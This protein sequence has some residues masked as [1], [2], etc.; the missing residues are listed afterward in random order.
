MLLLRGPDKQWSCV[1][2]VPPL[3]ISSTQI[4]IHTCNCLNPLIHY[5]ALEGPNRFCR[6]GLL[7]QLQLGREERVIIICFFALN[8]KLVALFR[9]SS[10][11]FPCSP[12][13]HIF[14]LT[15]K[16]PHSIYFFLHT[17]FSSPHLMLPHLL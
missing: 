12:L 7:N 2:R 1:F 13:L 15:K 4:C 10:F 9:M 14:K 17:T 16:T 11:C 3:C 6:D 8:S 5:I